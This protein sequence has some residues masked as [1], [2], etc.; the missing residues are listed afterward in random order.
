MT[1]WPPKQADQGEESG[2]A[3][4]AQRRA[5]R[6][7][8]GQTYSAASEGRTGTSRSQSQANWHCEQPG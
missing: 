3:S 2:C 5:V 4:R 8:E 1:Q 7:A 6:L